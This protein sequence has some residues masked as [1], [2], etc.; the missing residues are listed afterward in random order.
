MH[1]RFSK[2]IAEKIGR[3][4]MS[5]L[6][7]GTVVFA[8]IPGAE[9]AG[10]LT[11]VSAEE[12]SENEVGNAEDEADNAED[13]REVEEYTYSEYKAGKNYEADG[14]DLSEYITVEIATE[15]D[16]KEF[17]G[18]CTVDSWSRDKY[19]KLTADIVLTDAQNAYVPTFG[20]VFDGCGHSVTNIDING[21]GSTYGLFRYVQT[22][23]RIDDL[24]VKGNVSADYSAGRIGL[25]VGENYGT[26]SE[27]RAEGSVAGANE[28]GGLVGYNAPV[29]MI[30]GCSTECVVSG[31][32]SVG[33]VVGNNEGTVSECENKGAVN[34]IES[35]VT[36]DITEISMENIT[37]VNSTT[38]AAAFTDV[39]GIAGV[40]SGSI[41]KCTNAGTIGYEHVGY[42]IGGIA[43]RISQGYIAEC[44]NNGKIRG[45][46]DI[47]G[48]AGQMEPFLQME[49]MVDGV[50]RIDEEI[51]VLLDM[52]NRATDDLDYYGNKTSNV[53]EGMS[54]ALLEANQISTELPQDD[55]KTSI[56]VKTVLWEIQAFGCCGEWQA[57]GL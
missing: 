3:L 6:L 35:E 39:G 18:N 1:N 55:G 22:K 12:T 21:A 46:K 36:V 20:G 9:Y 51:N 41:I 54:D 15:A 40:S 29:G 14:Y 10:N 31:T 45:R 44:T 49:Y 38:N 23:G 56:E 30:I 17:A 43:G 52:M 42:N 53:L 7:I 5:G 19:V 32:H 27:C 26:I 24:V 25:L 50:S 37:A 34:T 4:L 8:G 33:G 11:L 48:I 57:E 2:S 28:V 16:W 13:E 47:G